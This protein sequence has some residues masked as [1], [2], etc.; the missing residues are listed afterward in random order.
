MQRFQCF[1]QT[2]KYI[3]V[4]SLLL[5]C[6]EVLTRIYSILRSEQLAITLMPAQ[7]TF[8]SRSRY[9]FLSRFSPLTLTTHTLF[10]FTF[11]LFIL[12]VCHF[13]LDFAIVGVNMI[14]FHIIMHHVSLLELSE[15]YNKYLTPTFRNSVQKKL[16]YLYLKSN[17]Y[18]SI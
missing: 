3:F 8:H 1:Q 18:S 15:R 11:S 12:N 5:I 6:S 16:R 10:V 4:L 17:Q 9:P 14:H 7:H 2:I 13:L